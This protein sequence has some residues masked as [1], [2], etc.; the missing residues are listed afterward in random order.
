MTVR[1]LRQWQEYSRLAGMPSRLR[2]A[3]LEPNGHYN[4][5]C[6]LCVTAGAS[7]DCS[8]TIT[9]ATK[10]PNGVDR[11]RSGYWPPR[12]IP[13]SLY[14]CWRTWGATARSSRHASRLS[15]PSLAIA[16]STDAYTS[17]SPPLALESPDKPRLFRSTV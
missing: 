3:L 14:L 8:N 9:Q 13:T 4:A 7:F 11:Y 2:Q 15:V 17:S 6:I 16:L 10:G 12:S 1:S 5:A